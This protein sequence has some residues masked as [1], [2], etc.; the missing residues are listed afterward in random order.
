MH[1]RIIFSG[2]REKPVQDLQIKKLLLSTRIIDTS[3]SI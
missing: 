3:M 1:C 2:A